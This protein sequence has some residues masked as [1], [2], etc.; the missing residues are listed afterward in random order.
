MKRKSFAIPLNKT[1]AIVM[2]VIPGHFT[3]SHFHL[4]HYLDL[5][6]LKTNSSIARDVAIELA[7]PYVS[8]TLIDT[9]VCV[10]GTE[11]IG[12][13]IADELTQEGTSV[14]NSD[15]EIHVVTPINNINRQLIFQSN[16]EELIDGQN[17]ILLVSSVS[18]GNTVKSALE[19]LSY[20]NGK[21][22]GISAL[23]NTL[24]EE[25]EYEIHSLFTN[26]DIPE[27]RMYSPNECVMCKAGRKL[28]A[29][30][31]PGGYIKM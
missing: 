26:E 17:I 31:M 7:A 28:D 24:N 19:C 25:S 13:Y 27:Y 16:M 4:T 20:Y 2:N 8:T 30:I 10:E 18:S 1:P 22:V 15:R 12:A 14:I 23:F 11:V 5:D 21:L 6:D 29:I 3:T 9:I